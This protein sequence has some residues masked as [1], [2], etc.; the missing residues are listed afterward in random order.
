MSKFARTLALYL[1]VVFLLHLSFALLGY[2]LCIH[3]ARNHGLSS[4]S[5]WDQHLQLGFFRSG[6]QGWAEK[7][8]GEAMFELTYLNST[9]ESLSTPIARANDGLNSK[10]IATPPA[11]DGSP[12]QINPHT[13]AAA[14]AFLAKHGWLA[15]GG[16]SGMVQVR[17]GWP[18]RTCTA[19]TVRS[20]LGRGNVYSVLGSPNPPFIKSLINGQ[21]PDDD[22]VTFTLPTSISLPALIFNSL[23]YAG[24]AF[25]FLNLF[26]FA[27]TWRSRQRRRKGLCLRCGYPLAEIATLDTSAPPNTPRPHPPI[28]P[29]C[30][31]PHPSS[32]PSTLP[33]TPAPPAG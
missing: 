22:L 19:V 17:V 6:G 21:S 25:G 1:F 31:T 29:E 26:S 7:T 23:I 30:G 33:S 3:H 2:A 13:F 11:Q 32:L 15:S 14:L 20:Q 9:V 18:M 10:V 24:F 28:C 8:A 4:G 5:N 16:S 27:A 12:R